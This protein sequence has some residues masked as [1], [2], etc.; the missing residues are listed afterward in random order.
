MTL[1]AGEDGIYS[2]T[3]EQW[4]KVA[5][6]SYKASHMCSYSYLPNYVGLLNDKVNA[7][8]PNEQPQRVH[9]ESAV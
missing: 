6:S 8:D 3:D 7:S 1:Q 2:R 9:E 4:S 5:E